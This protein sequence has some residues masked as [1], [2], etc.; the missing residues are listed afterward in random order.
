[1]AGRILVVEDEPSIAE[2]IAYVLGADGFQ[3]VVAGT[4]Q[5]ARLHVAAIAEFE[6]VVLDVGLP[7]G[8]GFELFQEIRAVSDVPVIFLTA[9]AGEVDRVVGLEMG[10]DDYIAKPFS[11]RE[12]CARIRT[13]LRRSKRSVREPASDA[14]AVAYGPFVVDE[15][16]CEVR[17]FDVAVPLTRYEYRLLAV[18][19]AAPG[20][21]FSREQLMSRAWEEP[22]MS[23]ERT[24]DAH[25][26]S[27]RAK[28]KGV[29]SEPDPIVTH[30]GFGYALREWS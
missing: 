13:I 12:L 29:R 17:Y 4:L 5:S 3:L 15:Q 8:T 9:R 10:A 27:L 24:V 18:L 23:L 7:D 22:E 25:V 6:L 1:M 28:L 30:R 19:L 14:A 21:V 16:R 20:R 26:K 11:P 2:N